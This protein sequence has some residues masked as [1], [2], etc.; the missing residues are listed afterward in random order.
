MRWRRVVTL[1]QLA[2]ILGMLVMTFSLSSCEDEE[3]NNIAKAQDCLDKITSTNFASAESCMEFVNKY[4]T[5]QANII[6]C[7][8]KLLAAGLTTQRIAKAYTAISDSTYTNKEAALISIFALDATKATQAQG[9]CTK[10][11]LNGFIYVAN[12][13]LIGSQ[14]AAAAAAAGIP[15]YT[16]DPTVPSN[17]P[18]DAEVDAILDNCTSDFTTTNCNHAAM[19]AAVETISESY[20][21]GN[22][23]DTDVCK[24][25]NEAVTAAGGDQALVSKQLFCLLDNKHYSATPTE[26]CY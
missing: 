16:Y 17:F 6:K 23:A 12:M 19:G 24:K 3:A 7:S 8:V 21:A 13:V 15:G 22:N 4:D 11:Q 5:Q 10:T 2:L 26:G 1:K 9:Y 25:I 14:M 20:C 18:T